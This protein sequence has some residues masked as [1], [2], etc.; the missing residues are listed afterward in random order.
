[1]NRVTAIAAALTLGSAGILAATMGSAAAAPLLH[2]GT[3]RAGTADAGARSLTDAAAPPGGPVPRGFLPASVTFVS[4]RDGWVLG[5]TKT[6]AHA[7]CTS[8]LRTTNGGRSWAGIPAPKFRLASLGTSQ[9]LQRLRFAT[10]RDGFAYG[11]QL[12]VTHNGGSSWHRV[13]QVPGLI[14]DLETAGGAAYAVTTTGTAQR[15]TVY[16]SPVGRDA[17]HRVSGLAVTSGYGG[18]GE[19]ALLIAGVFLGSLTWWLGISFGIASMR[20]RAGDIVMLWL[21]RISGAILLS[22]G[23]GLI[24]LACSGLLTAAG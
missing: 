16:E 1:M 3:A 9:G 19:I 5:T 2:A 17:W 24:V 18:L 20:H 22:S 6:C 4:A 23:S 11:S 13:R 10:R 8:V 14:S 21:N 15:Q 12:W 7:P